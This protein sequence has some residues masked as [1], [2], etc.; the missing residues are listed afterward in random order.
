[1]KFA[2]TLRMNYQQLGDAESVNKAIRIELE[3]TEV[4]LHKAWSSNES[5]Y[6]K[7]YTGL[8]RLETLIEWTNF[9]IFDLVWGNGESPWKLLRATILIL[10]LMSIIDVCKFKNTQS[11]YSYTQ[12][13]FEAPQ[14]FLG[15]LSPSNYPSPYF[16]LILFIR[17]VAFGLFMSILIKRLNRR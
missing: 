2:R 7:K 12:A 9:K 14:I 6:R 5:Y 15:T 1:M 4:H 16:T 8:K 13:F 11:I 17:L 10:L 3:A